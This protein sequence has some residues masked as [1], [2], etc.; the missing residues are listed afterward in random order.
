M[1]QHILVAA[2][3]EGLARF[4]L[5]KIIATDPEFTVAAT[6]TI[7][8]VAERAAKVVADVVVLHL[9]SAHRR[10]HELIA[11]IRE[12]VPRTRIVVVGHKTSRAHL[13]ELLNEGVVAYLLARSEASVLIAAIHAAVEGRRF[14]D[15]TVDEDAFELLEYSKTEGRK[16]LSIRETQVLKELVYGHTLKEIAAKL[17]VSD[18]SAET[19]LARVR[20]KLDLHSRADLVSYAIQNGVLGRD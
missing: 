16:L 6:T 18:K 4:A 14:V 20:V 19:Y 2:S 1:R 10:S 9:E 11:S 8:D 17:G 15:S 7:R 13:G 5:T 3:D 12:R